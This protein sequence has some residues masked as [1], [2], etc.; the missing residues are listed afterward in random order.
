MAHVN[1]GIRKIL[2][3]PS[4]YNFF[5][6]LIGGDKHRREHYSKYFDLPPG[7]KILDLG[8]G[9]ASLL[10]WLP[11]YIDYTGI[12]IEEKYIRWNLQ[13]YHRRGSFFLENVIANER[14]E[15]YSY[16]DAINAHG[17]LHHL[18]D[19]DCDILLSRAWK[20]LKPNGYLITVDSA[21]HDRQHLVSRWLVSRDRGQNVKT[22]NGYLEFAQRIFHNVK[23]EI[24]SDHLWIPF[25]VFIMMM[26]KEKQD[27]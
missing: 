27:G 22:A 3:L 10:R 1:T 15:W 23:G 16:F 7:S 26:V 8:C 6:S 12:D 19:E 2:E 17:L 11:D 25:S 4:L 18:S 20:Y 24:I 14:K 5:Q 21:Y 9:T 13:N